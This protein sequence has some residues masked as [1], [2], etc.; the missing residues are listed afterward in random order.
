MQTEQKGSISVH[1][2]AGNKHRQ[3][4]EAGFFQIPD[5]ALRTSK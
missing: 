4:L 3:K 2:A 5:T 1:P